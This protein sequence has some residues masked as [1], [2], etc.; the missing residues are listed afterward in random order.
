MSKGQKNGNGNGN[1]YPVEV[2]QEIKQEYILGQLSIAA[3]SRTYGPTRQAIMKQADKNGWARNMADD[4]RASVKKKTIE[5]E[6]QQ[7]VTPENYTEAI[8]KYG[9]LGAGVIGAHKVLFHKI[10]RR[11]DVTLDRLIRGDIIMD[12]LAAGK[13]IRKN[14]VVAATLALKDQNTTLKT[15]SEVVA[16]IVPLQRQAFNIDEDGSGADKI[17]YYIVGDLEK[18]ADAGMS[19]QITA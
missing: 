1:G 14:L 18:P 15:V 11:C 7:E 6:L 8:D 2:W 13:R 16:K 3:I 4:V 17:T 10:L 5:A 19:R 12:E 9:E